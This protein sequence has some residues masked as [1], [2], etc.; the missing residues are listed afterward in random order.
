MRY[1]DENAAAE[2]ML[3]TNARV[4]MQCAKWEEKRVAMVCCREMEVCK[5]PANWR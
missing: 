3:E 5:E 2:E 1:Q 4:K